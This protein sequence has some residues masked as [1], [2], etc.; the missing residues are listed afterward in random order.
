MMTLWF[1]SPLQESGHFFTIIDNVLSAPLEQLQASHEE[2]NTSGRYACLIPRS[3]TCAKCCLRMR[4]TALSPPPPLP[5]HTHTYTHRLLVVIDEL[6]DSYPV[7]NETFVVTKKKFALAI[8]PE[9]ETFGFPGEG[10]SA[11]LGN[12]FTFNGTRVLLEASDDATA[13]I[14]LP[15]TLLDGLNT[16]LTPKLIFSLFLN[17]GLFVRRR[18]YLQNS[19]LSAI[20]LGSIVIA[21]HIAGGVS[22]SG[23][24]DPVQTTF[25]TNPVSGRQ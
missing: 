22:V 1:P 10:F 8:Y 15:A 12:M 17:E 14:S 13:S 7:T 16:R 25:I 2:F 24:Q 19:N 3:Q 18:E 6:A 20:R 21:S 23:L 9:V 4:L 11:D 5:S